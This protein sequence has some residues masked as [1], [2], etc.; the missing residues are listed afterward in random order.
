MLDLA[1]NN[2][3]MKKEWTM[4]QSHTLQIQAGPQSVN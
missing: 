3:F 2:N 4:Y 1:D